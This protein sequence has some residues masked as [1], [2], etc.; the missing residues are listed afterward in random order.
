M[1][2]TADFF[3]ERIQQRTGVLSRHVKATIRFDLEREGD[4]RDHWWVAFDN[5]VVQVSPEERPA[6]CIVR[7]NKDLFDHIVTG[8]VRIVAALIRNQVKVEGRLTVFTIFRK[9]LPG[10][11]GARDPRDFAREWKAQQR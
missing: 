4:G 10:R 8:Q 2:P 3:L 7:A 9:L 11:P 5:G 6:D 1:D